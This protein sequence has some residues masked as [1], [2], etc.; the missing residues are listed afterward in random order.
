MQQSRTK[1]LIKMEKNDKLPSIE[2]RIQKIK[3]L[4]IHEKKENFFSY[5]FSRATFS[6]LSCLFSLPICNNCKKQR[7]GI[8]YFKNQVSDRTR[9]KG[10]EFEKT[11]FLTGFF[12]QC[13]ACNRTTLCKFFAI[14]IP[15][16]KDM[17]S[18]LKKVHPKL[19]QNFGALNRIY[20]MLS[21]DFI[22]YSSSI[23]PIRRA[24]INFDTGLG[25]LNFWGIDA[26]IAVIEIVQP[27]IEYYF[28]LMDNTRRK[29]KLVKII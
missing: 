11:K 25:R 7:R 12:T 27:I 29:R 9:I 19:S 5:Y 15:D 6:D 16:M 8:L 24:P 23:N 20:Q 10:K 13:S 4:N 17:L 2:D 28:Q 3:V 22:H 1:L 14:G 18:L 21:A 26:L